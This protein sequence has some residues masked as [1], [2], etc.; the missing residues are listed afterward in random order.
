MAA[1]DLI[2]VTRAKNNLP[3]IT[4]S[5]QDTRLGIL[6][7]AAS[8]AIAKYCRRD[9]YARSYD[10]LYSAAGAGR[11]LLRQYPVQAVTS[12][13]Y[14]PVG[15]LKIQ[16]TDTATHQQ[17]RVRVTSTG[18]TLTRVASGVTTTSTLTFAGNVTLQALAT[19]IIALGNGWTA[20]VLGDANDYGKWPS[21]DLYIA[22]S[23]GDGVSSQG[24]INVRGI[25]GELQLHV[26]ELT[27][28]EFDPRGW[29][30]RCEEL[31][32][33]CGVNS[34]RVQYTA[35]YTTIPE[36]VQEACAEWVSEMYWQTLRDPSA[37]AVE[38]PGVTTTHWR[39]MAGKPSAVVQRLLAPY[40]R[41]V[42]GSH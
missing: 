21:T 35:G 37:V 5:S 12:V 3:Q 34:L 29:L 7:T 36:A 11:L 27:D 30:V 38:Q 15:V 4:D 33:P 31:G 19:A 32:W 41:F 42:V 1:K 6:I 8:D 40:R 39:P 18:L 16:N 25:Y 22:P 9:F 13:R 23:F 2:N 28:F 24:N 26:N 20:T 17:A 10:E 14:G